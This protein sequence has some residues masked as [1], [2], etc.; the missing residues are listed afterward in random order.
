[1]TDERVAC[2]KIKNEKERMRCEL[3]E[4]E[5][6]NIWVRKSICNAGDVLSV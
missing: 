4:I 6:K 1:M 5:R 3:T 2:N